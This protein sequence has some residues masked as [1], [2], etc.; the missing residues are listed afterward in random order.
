MIEP[1]QIRAAR[2]LLDWTI[3]DLAKASGLNKDSIKNAERSHTQPRTTTMAA[4]RDALERSGVVF[5]EGSGVRL[6]NEIVR[7]YE[8]LP[9]IEKLYSEIYQQALTAEKEFVQFGLRYRD[10]KN[11]HSDTFIKDYSQ[12]MTAIGKNLFRCIVSEDERELKKANYARYRYWAAEKFLGVPFYV[13]GDSLII[14]SLR[15]DRS[16]AILISDKKIAEEYRL[17]F[18]VMWQAAHD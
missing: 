5:T 8:G 17:N 6:R 13:I 14:I 9:G 11:F 3:E 15:G 16:Q 10:I 7:I 1:A 4:I 18:D 12:K 2:A